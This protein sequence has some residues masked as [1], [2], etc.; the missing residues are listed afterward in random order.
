MPQAFLT[1]AI[2][3]VISAMRLVP[4]PERFVTHDDRYKARRI[5]ES[6]RWHSYPIKGP[7]RLRDSRH[8]ILEVALDVG[9]Q[10]PSHF[11]RM[12]RKFCGHRSVAFP[13]SEMNLAERDGARDAETAEARRPPT[14]PERRRPNTR[15]L[16]NA[17]LF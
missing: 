2:W 5:Y 13:K 1:R 9:F 4:H 10:N 17:A 8:D 14:R 11:A 3:R 7:A 12:F 6:T 15:R 16:A